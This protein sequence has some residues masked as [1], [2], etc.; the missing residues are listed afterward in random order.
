MPTQR[1][2]LPLEVAA[3][4]GCGQLHSVLTAATDLGEDAVEDLTDPVLERDR[5]GQVATARSRAGPGRRPSA[6]WSGRTGNAK[7][8][9]V[10]TSVPSHRARHTSPT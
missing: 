1:Q 8:T 2:T 10:G 4:G 7:R 5:L 9:K 6:V 3:Y